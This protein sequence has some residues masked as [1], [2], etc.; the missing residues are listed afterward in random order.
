ML[1]NWLLDSQPLAVHQN[2]QRVS[3]VHHAWLQSI[4]GFGRK[5][6]MKI[7]CFQYGVGFAAPEIPHYVYCMLC[8]CLVMVYIGLLIC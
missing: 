1:I 7:V 2:R 3:D 8:I 6:Y 4:A 5:D